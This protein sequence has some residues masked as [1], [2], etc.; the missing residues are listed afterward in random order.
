MKILLLCLVPPIVFFL[1]GITIKAEAIPGILGL[2]VGVAGA[3]FTIMSIW[4]AFLY[5]NVLK[6]LR[7]ENLVNAEFSAD[8]E[9]TTRL[10][11]ILSVIIQSAITMIAS[12]TILIASSIYQGSSSKGAETLA[13]IYQ[14]GLL[15]FTGIQVIALISTITINMSFIT[16]LEKQRKKRAKDWDT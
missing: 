14:F 13:S 15:Y 10:K 5:P 2:L 1:F 3:I 9:D 12:I 6:T 11:E 16:A 4:V 7:G 8:G